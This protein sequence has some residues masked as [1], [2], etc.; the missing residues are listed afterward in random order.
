MD[1][2]VYEIPLDSIS[3]GLS[4]SLAEEEAGLQVFVERD[5]QDRDNLIRKE[6]KE[7]LLL[8][9]GKGQLE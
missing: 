3:E 6:S 9:D 4:E 2:E 5:A 7:S 1:K 8:Y